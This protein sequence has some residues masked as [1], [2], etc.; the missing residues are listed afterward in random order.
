MLNQINNIVLLTCPAQA[1]RCAIKRWPYHLFINGGKRCLRL[2]IRLTY[3]GVSNQFLVSIQPR[4]R[5][6]DQFL[7]SI[8]PR[9]RIRAQF[10]VS[11]QPRTRIRA[12]F[13]VSIKPRT[14][15]R[16]QFLV[17][18]RPRTRAF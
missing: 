1:I 5:I 15:I 14:R 16:A 13:L 2:K 11:I 6:R 3:F 17:S 8:K 9:T 12:Q 18:I 7:I 4:T 10:L